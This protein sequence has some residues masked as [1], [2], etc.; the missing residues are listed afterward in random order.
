KPSDRKRSA[1]AFT[2]GV[3][4][5]RR[6]TATLLLRSDAT[7][8]PAAASQGT[9]TVPGGASTWTSA[10]HR[11]RHGRAHDRALD[12]AAAC[13]RNPA[14]VHHLYGPHLRRY[15]IAAGSPRQ[16]TARTGR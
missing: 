9:V 1:I 5:P 16:L 13:V 14:S 3:A 11:H 10:G 6:S 7:R 12:E 4:P 15:C 8:P 2:N